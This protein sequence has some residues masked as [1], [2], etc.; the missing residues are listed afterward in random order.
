[1]KYQVKPLENFEHRYTISNKGRIYDTLKDKFLVPKISVGSREKEKSMVIIRLVNKNNVRTSL[2][3]HTN[4]AKHFC[5]NPNEYINVY[6][7]DRN[8]QN[9]NAWNLIYLAP[10]VHYWAVQ[11]NRG[12][13]KREVV[14]KGG[15]AKHYDR[16]DTI[17]KIKALKVRGIEEQNLLK[18]YETNDE[19]HL[20]NIYKT[21]SPKIMSKAKL[22]VGELDA[23]DVMLD[24]F[25]YFIDY[26]KRNCIQ[27]Y[28]FKTWLTLFEYKAIDYWKLQAKLVYTDLPM[29][30][31]AP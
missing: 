15:I 12:K 9:N 13:I 2:L 26:V 29:Q 3:L 7:K 10:D 5:S 11:L 28:C 4:V 14:L 17:K 23:Y 6:H 19:T 1:M 18:F 21:L 27:N 31:I 30:D 16:D 8:I 25:I 22:R 20:W 24:S